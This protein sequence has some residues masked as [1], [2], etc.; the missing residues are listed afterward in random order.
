MRTNVNS[1][2]I[3]TIMK[4]KKLAFFRE[5]DYYAFCYNNKMHNNKW[6]N[7]EIL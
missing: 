7:H 4:G 3:T 1:L 6:G 2:V 5:K